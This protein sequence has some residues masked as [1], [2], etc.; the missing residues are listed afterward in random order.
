[1]FA[2]PLSIVNS[3]TWA[4]DIGVQTVIRT[5]ARLLAELCFPTRCLGCDA[6][7]SWFCRTCQRASEHPRSTTACLRCSRLTPTPGALCPTHR[8]DLGL[9][10]LLAYGNYRTAPIRRAIHR[11]KY[12]GIW[13][14]APALVRCARA[15][16]TPAGHPAWAAVV[17]IPSTPQHDRIRGFS[18]AQ[19][20]AAAFARSYNIPLKRY[21]VRRPT[22]PQV[23]LDRTERA[24]NIR[25]AFSI[26]WPARLTGSVLVVD[27]VMTTGA[28]LREAA[29]VLRANGVTDIWAAVLAEDPAD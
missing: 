18:P 27:D 22:D 4:Y 8:G 16:W 26:T 28:T 21:L 5:A 13:A 17:P 20:L 23:G 2:A 10:G 12:V 24:K 9:N 19:E 25:G 29:R 6:P 7:G 15:R 1:M 11:F 3:K 14:A